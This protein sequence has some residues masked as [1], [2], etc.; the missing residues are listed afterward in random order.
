MEGFF[1]LEMEGSWEPDLKAGAVLVLP[2]EGRGPRRDEA[3]VETGFDI[4]KETEAVLVF[5]FLEASAVVGLVVIPCSC[6]ILNLRRFTR[7]LI[8]SALI[9]FAIK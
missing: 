5:S 6:L 9:L 3:A 8:C 1:S 4:A 2:I 7:S